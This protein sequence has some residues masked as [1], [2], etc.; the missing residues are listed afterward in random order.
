MLL[1]SIHTGL[2]ERSALL[3]R[4]VES[5]HREDATG[6]VRRARIDD[7]TVEEYRLETGIHTTSDSLVL[8]HAEWGEFANTLLVQRS[9]PIEVLC[10]L[11]TLW[12]EEIERV[13]NTGNLY[14]IVDIVELRLVARSV[15]AIVRDVERLV[16]LWS[17]GNRL[18][19][20]RR[21]VDRVGEHRNVRMGIDLL[22]RGLR[23]CNRCDAQGN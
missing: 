4:L 22:A 10:H 20:V 14:T 7:C 8:L 21:S 13:G 3:E 17:L 18:E 1:G 16:A 11:L 6:V 23:K 9:S 12:G 2:Q 5:G 15:T 19:I